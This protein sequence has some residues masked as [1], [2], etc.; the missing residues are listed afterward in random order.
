MC[1]VTPHI[2]SVPWA[3][4][5]DHNV[6]LDVIPEPSILDRVNWFLRVDV[7]VHTLHDLAESCP[8]VE[9][10]VCVLHTSGGSVCVCVCVCAC[11][12]AFVCVC[13]RACV[14][15]RTRMCVYV[16]MRELASLHRKDEMLS[17]QIHT[18]SLMHTY[19][20]VAMEVAME[21]ADFHASFI[22]SYLSIIY[23][24]GKGYKFCTSYS[25][26][27]AMCTQHEGNMIR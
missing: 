2:P 19:A 5:A 23:I 1:H 9:G 14:W 6:L 18:F 16:E 24:F 4:L 20:C 8:Q 27:V 15:V 21:V 17:T 3:I 10:Q 22:H 25:T 11:V 26:T 7:Q 12:C 13:V